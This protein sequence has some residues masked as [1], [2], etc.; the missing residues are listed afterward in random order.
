[1]HFVPTKICDIHLAIERKEV[2][3]FQCN[4]AK[5]KYLVRAVFCKISQKVF[6]WYENI[7]G[8]PAEIAVFEVG[9]FKARV[10]FENRNSGNPIDAGTCCVEKNHNL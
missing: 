3:S 7:E 8:W 2:C 6:A 5:C 9:E 10:S 1:M 4:D